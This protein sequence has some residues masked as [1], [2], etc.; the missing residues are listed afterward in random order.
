[1]GGAPECGAVVELSSRELQ[2]AK[3]S[4]NSPPGSSR[5][6][7][8]R[9]TLLP[10]APECETVIELSSRELQNAKLSSNSPPGSSRMRSCRRTLLQGAPECE[11]VVELSSLC[12]CDA[13]TFT[14]HFRRNT[15]KRTL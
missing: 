7:S 15:L 2:N 6:R 4:S 11:T 9:R 5:M 14:E 13:V 12:V 10:G 1:M 8:C 3:L